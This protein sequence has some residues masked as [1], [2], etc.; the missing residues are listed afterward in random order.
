MR[1]GLTDLRLPIFPR[2]LN[3]G[4]LTRVPGGMS[5]LSFYVPV[6]HVQLIYSLALCL[7]G[8]VSDDGCTS[9]SWLYDL[10]SFS[11]QQCFSSMFHSLRTEKHVWRF[12]FA[13]HIIN[14]ITLSAGSGSSGQ[15]EYVAPAPRC[16]HICQSS[17]ENPFL[18]YSFG[19]AN[20]DTGR[21]MNDM[22]LLNAGSYPSW[23]ELPQGGTIPCPRWHH[24]SAMFGNHLFVYGGESASYQ[25]LSDLHAFDVGVSWTFP[26]HWLLFHSPKLCIIR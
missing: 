24:G 15:S 8:G 1:R 4:C 23:D 10:G 26:T 22:W 9:E 7:F 16:G 3:S 20:L 14:E 5:H 19:G 6:M 18:L 21:Y 11:Q 25:T 17:T 13:E 2:A 12:I